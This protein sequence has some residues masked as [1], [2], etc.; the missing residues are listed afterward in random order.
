MID[1]GGRLAVDDSVIIIDASAE[2]IEAGVEAE[3][4]AENLFAA[5]PPSMKTRGKTLKKSGKKSGKKTGKK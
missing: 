5:T 1:G 2:S 4:V 3:E